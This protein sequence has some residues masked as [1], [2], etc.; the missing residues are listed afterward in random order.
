MFD[1]Q[2]MITENRTT[3]IARIRIVPM[4]SDT[5]DSS[6]RRI[7]FMDCGLPVGGKMTAHPTR[8]Y[9]NWS[10]ELPFDDSVRITSGTL[11]LCRS[12]RH[13]TATRRS[14]RPRHAAG[15][16]PAPVSRISWDG[17]G[18]FYGSMRIEI[19]SPG[20]S[21]VLPHEN[22]SVSARIIGR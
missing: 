3:V 14:D 22:T 4:T 17:F 11:G 16:V 8:R 20:K 6:S 19:F 10:W 15:T 2:I 9:I 13:P 12:V 18:Y 7:V 5:P 1:T 21:D